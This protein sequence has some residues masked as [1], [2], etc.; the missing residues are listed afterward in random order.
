[1]GR[2]TIG[3]KVSQYSTGLEVEPAYWDADTS[4]ASTDGRKENLAGEKKKELVRLNDALSA[5]EAK[6]R[7]AYKEN[8]DSYGFVS[9]EIIKN[10]VTGKS[11][12][13]ETLLAL[14]DEHNEEYAK[15]VGIDRTR[16]SY[17][18]YLTTR[19]HIH[20]FMKYKYGMEDMPLRSLTMRFMTD[21]TFYLSTVLRLKV[22][23]YNDYLILLH[24]MTRFALKRHILKRDPFAGHK[25]EKITVNHRYLTGEQ[26]EKL[27]K[28]KLP[29]YRLCHTRD[30]FVFSTF[31]GI[32]RADL[33]NL[34]EDNIITKEDGSKWIHIA[35]QKTKAEC[36][37]KLLDIPLRIIE[38]YRGEGKDGKLFFV[39][40]TSS[41]CRNLKMIAEQCDLGCHL[42]YYM[43]RHSFATLIC[44]NNE[45]YEE[46]EKLEKKPKKE[47]T[48][49]EKRRLE[50]LKKKTK[51]REAAISILRGI[52]IRMPL[53]IYGAELDNEDEEI[54]IDNFAEKIDPRSWEEF[55]PKGVSKQKFNAFKK[56]YDPDIFRA[57]GKRIRA[58]AKA[59]D[60]LSVEE[61]IGRITDIFS[62]FRNP[63]KE[64]V[65]TPWRVVNMHLGDC[66]GGYCFYDKEYEHT[67][68]EPHFIDHGQVTEEV[69]TPDSRILEI[70]SK[71]GLYPLYMAYSIYRSRLKDSTI[72]A[73]TLEEQQAVWDKVVAE[74]IF[75]VCKTPMA[76]SIT[77][78]TL[79]GFRGTKTNMYAPDD[80]INKIKNQPELFIKK[81][82]DLVGKDMKFNAVVGNPP[83]Q[84]VVEQKESSNGQKVSISIFHY[85]QTISE[86]LGK[87][88]SLIYPGARWIHRSGKGLEKFGL[89]QIN[90]C[91]L[92][93]LEFFPYST[94][95]F[96]DVA[97]ADGL[98]IVLKDMDKTE[99]GFTYRYSKE[100]KTISIHADNPGEDLFPLNPNDDEIV[101]K[102]DKAIKEYRCL[103][104]SVL[105]RSLFGIESDFVEKNPSLVRKYNDG[106]YFNPE[107]EIK[108]FTNDKAG[109]SGRARWYVAN[110]NIISS[111][112]E[113]L[114]RWKII[115]SSANAGGQ[116]RSNQ[117]A[118]IDNYSAF[119]R[120]RVALKTFE[121]EKEAR[122]FFKYATSEIIRFAFLMT[123][124]SLTSLA[125]KVPD[126]LDYADNKG[127]IDF[128]GDVNMQLYKLFEIDNAQQKYIKEVLLSKG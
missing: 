107:T 113:Y 19:K 99:K 65:L 60:K 17:V 63:D 109:K 39:P 105:P 111:G 24:K 124:E 121:T 9:A 90:D 85:F 97:I 73:D 54:T 78:R 55:M 75:V 118:V 123:D 127:L 89:A 13:K 46:K 47:L 115:V 120:S 35:R 61:R 84:E 53:L 64:T 18:R 43:S 12:V 110:K 104:D 2:I 122:N 15:R 82:H 48:E 51:N 87:Y 37:I 83:Y 116:K 49:E 103:H 58:M 79:I 14:M 68:D 41:L 119:G 95:V 93:M 74:N 22:S 40:Q 11:Q 52:S 3:G 25:I 80:L 33:A 50:E 4:R 27:L 70:N 98:S 57:A 20:N 16:H 28:A 102:L 8:V 30:L 117:I 44:L 5:L 125:K 114:G 126:L 34:T 62:T 23:A 91:H 42:T 71:S 77:K 36:H 56:Y 86:R 67:I 1:M 92:M 21:F 10:A 81:V 76:K 128:N 6:A 66:L 7:A 31:T 112:T 69:F 26:F 29:T 96:K 101:R 45:E 32:G 100:S 106:D 88:T 72:S 59:A 108:L 94:D 38:K